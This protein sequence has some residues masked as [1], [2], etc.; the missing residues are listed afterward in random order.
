MSEKVLALAAGYC[1]LNC[2]SYIIQGI[3][4]IIAVYYEINEKF[5]V[6]DKDFIILDAA[7]ECIEYSSDFVKSNWYNQ[8]TA[9]GSICIPL[10]DWKERKTIKWRIEFAMLKL[11]PYPFFIGFTNHTSFSFCGPHK[12]IAPT[13]KA[14]GYLGY[15]FCYYKKL[16]CEKYFSINMN[17]DKRE[18]Y[19][20]LQNELGTMSDDEYDDIGCDDELVFGEVVLE[21]K[22]QKSWICADIKIYKHP[23]TCL[24]GAYEY[25][26]SKWNRFYKPLSQF[27]D[28]F[29]S[30]SL[31]HG[32][33]AQILSM[34]IDNELIFNIRKSMKKE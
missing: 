22:I 33:T 3:I 8:K 31:P 10:Q 2:F 15:A 25:H 24:K 21:M 9:F 4:N 30:I 7:G 14:T 26:D 32:A 16:W 13:E 28:W 19:E 20:R 6:Y 27:Q 23:S 11:C 29:L 12:Y 1:R 34:D 18:R 5:T 17:H